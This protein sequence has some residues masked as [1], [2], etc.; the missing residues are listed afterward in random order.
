MSRFQRFTA[1]LRRRHVP[2]T[3][4]VYI[5]AAWAA[6][7]FADVVVPNLGWPQ[8]L[9]EAVIVAAAIGF[10][11]VLGLSWFLEWGPEGVH[12]AQGEAPGGATPGAARSSYGPWAVALG[13]LV[14]G[15]SAAVV[16][17]GLS[18]EAEAVAEGGEDAAPTRFDRRQGAPSPPIVPELVN[19]DVSRLVQDA[20]QQEG[21][22]SVEGLAGGDM[23]SLIAAAR[24]LGETAAMGANVPLRIVSPSAWRVD[25][26]HPAH[27]GDTVVIRGVARAASGVAAVELDGRVVARSDSAPREL[28]FEARWVAGEGVGLRVVRILVRPAEGEPFA[29]PYRVNLLPPA[30]EG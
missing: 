13:V 25:I 27:A 21:L 17:A 7:Q 14:V 30:P 1:E 6:I 20:L 15:I 23:D 11:V 10:P 5:I 29:R 19:P 4:A 24:R 22:G 28:P 8:W 3:A 26:P 9:V 12:R 2:Q 16:V 18:R